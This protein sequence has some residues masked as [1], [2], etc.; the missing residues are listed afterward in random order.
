MIPSRRTSK[1][2]DSRNGSPVLLFL[3]V[4]GSL[5]EKLFLLPYSTSPPK[6]GKQ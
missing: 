3:I 1:G 6:E 2:H 5:S 4:H